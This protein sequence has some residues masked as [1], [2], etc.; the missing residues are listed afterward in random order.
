MNQHLAA[1]RAA[2]ATRSVRVG[3]LGSTAILLGSLSPAYLP[4]VSPV[5]DVLETLNFV[6][7]VSKW[8]GTA[9]TLLGLGLLLESWLRLR[10]SRRRELGYPQ[11]RHWAVIM[12]IAFPLLLGPPTFSHDAYSYAAQG[13]LIFNGLNPYEVGPNVLPGVFAD[14]VAWV[15]RTTPAPY[16]PLA[17]ELSRWLVE[18]AQ[19]RPYWSAVLMRIPAVIGVGLI[20]W[21]VP[22]IANRLRID[23]SAASWFVLLN[24]IL[25]IDFIGGAHN[26]SL[27]TGLM[28]GAILLTMRTRS[29][30]LGALVVGLAAA[31]KQPAFLAAVALPFLVVPLTRYRWRPLVLAVVRIVLSLALA[32]AVFAIVS[33]ATWLGFGWIYAVNVPGLVDTISPFTV[34]GH[35]VQAPINLLGLDATGRAAITVS[36]GVG[37]V[38]AG[39]GTAILAVRFLGKQPISFLSWSLLLVALSLPATH[40]WYVLWGG[41]LFPMARPSQRWLRVAILVTAVLL[42]AA[43]LNFAM[44]NGP[45]VM[46]VL[47][48][49][50]AWESVHTHELSQRWD[51]DTSPEP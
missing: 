32:I 46:I 9:L 47:L 45:W 23:A 22:R 19:F 3:M 51:A 21:C 34:L 50:A 48:L 39:I 49:W 5:W 6:G 12:V 11:L 1:L 20:G 33:Y 30:W 36:R 40:S 14:Q 38:V 2:L 28:L 18:L 29:W 44:R 4:Q 42:A 13:W 41:A 27:M 7:P 24:P 35:V 15:W 43:A 10:P 8:V 31:V 16:G 26:D 25:I 17:L 37:L